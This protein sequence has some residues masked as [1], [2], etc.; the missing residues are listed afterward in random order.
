M[1]GAHLLCLLDKWTSVV[2]SPPLPLL[3]PTR[4]VG[5]QPQP[6][7]PGQK[8]PRSGEESPILGSSPFYHHLSYFFKLKRRWK[9]NGTYLFLSPLNVTPLA[10]RTRHCFLVLFPNICKSL[11]GPPEFHCKLQLALWPLDH[12]LPSSLATCPPFQS[13]STGGF[14]GSHISFHHCLL[15]FRGPLSVIPKGFPTILNYLPLKSIPAH[16]LSFL[17]AAS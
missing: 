7:P 10:S 5:H 4:P 13:P 16:P 8:L 3:F 9:Q 11:L 1:C 15:F 2:S 6:Q 14:L 12:V 17:K